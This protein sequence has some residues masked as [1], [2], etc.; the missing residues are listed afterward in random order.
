MGLRGGFAIKYGRKASWNRCLLFF[1]FHCLIV[2]TCFDDNW[3][4]RQSLFKGPDYLVTFGVYSHQ[5]NQQTL[6]CIVN[7]DIE[8]SSLRTPIT[9]ISQNIAQ[10]EI[11]WQNNRRQCTLHNMSSST[12]L[13]QSSATSSEAGS[14]RDCYLY[15]P[16]NSEQKQVQILIASAQSKVF[17]H[18][19]VYFVV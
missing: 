7:H 17:C 1:N 8:Y 10:Q 16:D 18:T 3:N 11:R 13:L 14:I 9:A 6:S 4:S 15:N 19:K 12:T 2:S 5:N